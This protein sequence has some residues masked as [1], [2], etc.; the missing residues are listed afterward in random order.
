M[1][2]TNPTP[3]AQYTPF[4]KGPAGSDVVLK[5]GVKIGVTSKMMVALGVLGATGGFVSAIAP[6]TSLL[7][8]LLV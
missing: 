4:V 6:G 8:R 7:E 2:T 3:G 1:S 5:T